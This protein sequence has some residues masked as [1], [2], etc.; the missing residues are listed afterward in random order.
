MANRT[1]IDTIRGYL[2]QFDLTILELLQLS[3]DN[4]VVTIEGIEDI[5]ITD[6]NE[7]IAIQCKYHSKTEYNHSVIAKPIRLMLNHFKGVLNGTQNRIKYLYFG[8]FQQGHEK[9]IQ[10]I[11]LDFLKSNL[12]T[13]KKENIEYK[14]YEDLQLNDVHLQNFLSLLEININA[15]SHEQQ[16][17]E[18]YKILKNQIQCD[19]FE[20]EH[21]YYNNA[22]KVV[23]TLAKEDNILKRKISKKEFIAEINSK[24]VFFHK[25]FIQIRGKKQFLSELKNKYF[26]QYNPSPF[27][28]FFLLEVDPNSYNRSELKDIIF[29]IS[30]KWGNV[31]SKK[32]PNTFSPYL[33]INGILEEELLCIKTE[34]YNENLKSIDGFNFAG[35]SF[36]QKSIIEKATYHNQIK[37][38]IINKIGYIDLI[39]N[40]LTNKTKEIYQF[41]LSKPYFDYD[42]DS[43]KHIKIQVEAINDLKNII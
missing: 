30:K 4:S 23:S 25:W 1:A 33:Y 9:L 29:L 16:L 40:E 17:N 39:I 6:A 26:V 41:Y 42:N 32:D 28:R 12:L 18:I 3:N 21:F 35:S 31:R 15:K 2:Y 20:A 19:D 34:L 38:K 43:V 11:T 27:E 7:E 22:L 13:Y 24:N 36:N 5:D 8:H 37:L 14:H 10:P